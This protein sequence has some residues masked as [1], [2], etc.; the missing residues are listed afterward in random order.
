[1][2]IRNHTLGRSP[3]NDK[4]GIRFHFYAIE[5][6]SR[7]KDIPEVS[8]Q[9][10]TV[11]REGADHGSIALCV[12]YWSATRFTKPYYECN[13]TTFDASKMTW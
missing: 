9:V 12:G 1:L 5:I 2:A 7:H 11:Y 8:L 10:D 6:A 3:I 13:K 4:N